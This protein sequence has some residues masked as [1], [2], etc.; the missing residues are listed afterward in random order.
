MKQFLI[1]IFLFFNQSCLKQPAVLSPGQWRLTIKSS[2]IEIPALV[3]VLDEKNIFLLRGDEKYKLEVVSTA[4]TSEIRLGMHVFDA[5]LVLD[6][7]SSNEVRGR[8]IRSDKN[9]IQ[10]Y[11]ILLEKDK[12]TLFYVSCE[13]EKSKDDKN[14]LKGKWKWTFEPGTENESS[15]LG[16]FN[17]NGCVVEGSLATSTGDYGL[18]QG[19]FDGQEFK[20][21]NFDGVFAFVAKGSVENQKLQGEFFTTSG[22]K[23]FIAVRDQTFNLPDATEQTK[24]IKNRDIKFSLPSIKGDIVSL[25]DEKFKNK[26]VILQIYGSWCPNCLDE[27]KFLSKWYKENKEKN[28][29]IIALAFERTI[30]MEKAKNNILK[31]VDSYG[32][33]YEILIASKDNTITPDQV[34]P[35]ENFI[36][37]PTTIFL[38]RKHEVVKVH[39]GF[40]GTAT[41]D[42]Y[43]K[44]VN[45]FHQTIIKMVK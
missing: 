4:S 38:N 27:I 19:Y 5:E 3:E 32:V 7:F 10:E 25:S 2:S 28:V 40:A 24:I 30:S 33:E 36:S 14:T 37:F 44:F 35:L 34:L 31:T 17:Q 23:K 41:G 15:V 11:K 26:A 22:V 9:P 8:W 21:A 43:D 20:L 45:F 18:M 12:K 13:K 42:E 29:E 16:I 1:L 6:D 39:A